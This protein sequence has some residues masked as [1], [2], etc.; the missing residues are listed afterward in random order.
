[1]S[2]TH[3]LEGDSIQ[4]CCKLYSTGMP[5]NPLLSLTFLVQGLKMGQK[6]ELKGQ[7]VGFGQVS[8]DEVICSCH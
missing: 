7:K 3:L 4:G 1:M 5:A 2:F 8:L 6:R